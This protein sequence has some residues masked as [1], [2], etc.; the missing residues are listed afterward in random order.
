[1][2]YIQS[3]ADPK[4]VARFQRF[5]GVIAEKPETRDQHTQ[6]L[7]SSTDDSHQQQGDELWEDIQHCQTE[8][9]KADIIFE[10]CRTRKKLATNNNDYIKSKI[11]DK[12]NQKCNGISEIEENFINKSNSL[13]NGYDKTEII[14][15][16]N[17][18]SFNHKKNCHM[19]A[20]AS[21]DTTPPVKTPVKIKYKSL[22][23][24]AHFGAF[25]GNEE[26]YLTFFPFC[27]WNLDGVVIRQVI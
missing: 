22:L 2:E 12:L 6:T 15:S 18:H 13:K 10:E 1:M 9:N 23:Y 17:G 19:S 20:A 7:K 16:C 5:C 25:L 3:L 8:V 26:F 24:L 27:L 21:D 11:Q 4:H 14:H